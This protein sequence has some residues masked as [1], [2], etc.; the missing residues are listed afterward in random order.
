[1]PT[2]ISWSPSPGSPGPTISIGA[3][4]RCASSPASSRTA[5]PAATPS[6]SSSAS[7]Y[8]SAEAA[9]S[10]AA[11]LARWRSSSRALAAPRVGNPPPAPLP[12]K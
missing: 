1:M 5:L 10:S 3:P 7:A 6:F 9:A 12:L 11:I 8:T 4:I 2:E